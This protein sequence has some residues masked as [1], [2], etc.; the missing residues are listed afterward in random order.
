M[1]KI[2]D[3]TFW[4]SKKNMIFE[5][6][7]LQLDAG[8]IYGLLGKN[9]VGKTTLLK[10]ITGLS[11]PKSGEVLTNGRIP[12]K[13]EPG[14]LS[15]IFLVPEEI[16]VPSVKP[17]KFADVYAP[18]YP[19]FDLSQFKDLLKKF[20]VDED[21]N[22]SKM[23]AGQRKKAMISFAL[24][25]NPKYLFLDEPTNGLDIP[26]KAIFRSLLAN[27]FSEERTIILSTHQVRDLQSLI[28][29]VIVLEKRKIVLNQSLE[30][31]ARKF[32]FGHS[33]SSPVPGEILYSANR[34]LGHSVVS[35]NLSGEP[36]NVDLETLFNACIEIPEII[37]TAFNH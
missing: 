36:G 8:H 11:F 14:F 33:T 17:I 35:R 10:L 7:K 12:G 27:A 26:S 25:S 5:N 23:S 13:R 34:E 15:E 6:L 20:E 3:L 21:Q 30:E 1:I 24:A 9:G 29:S 18:F 19:G 32:S 22:L 37:S 28:D 31:V 4:Y 16:S 2:T